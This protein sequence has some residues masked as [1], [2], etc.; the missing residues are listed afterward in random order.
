MPMDSVAVY[1]DPEASHASEIRYV[2]ELLLLTLGARYRSIFTLEESTSYGATLAYLRDPAV[3]LQIGTRVVAVQMAPSAPAFFAGDAAYPD[4]AIGTIVDEGTPIPVLFCDEQTVFDVDAGLATARSDGSIIIPLDFLSSAFWFL[5][6]REEAMS[7]HR[8][9]WGRFG[10]T[11]SLF[12]REPR[13]TMTV[14]DTYL[15]LL[16]KLLHNTLC[17]GGRRSWWLPRWP[18][19]APFAFCGTHDVDALRKWHPRRV[20]GE[21]GRLRQAWRTSGLQGAVRR[22]WR[23]VGELVHNPNPYD[24]VLELA[25]RERVLD[26]TATYFFLAGRH[27]PHDAQYDLSRDESVGHLIQ[28]VE[29]VGHEVGLHGSFTTLGDT[30]RL[31]EELRL[32][33]QYAGKVVGQRQHYLRFDSVVSWPAYAAVGIEYDSSLGFADQ[34]G[35]RAG[36]SF[37]IFPYDMKRHQVF[38]FVEI[39]LLVMDATLYAYRGLDAAD[40]WVE[41][42]AVLEHVARIEGCFTI[43][44]HNASFDDLDMPGYGDIY[45][46]AIEWAQSR[47]AWMASMADVSRWWMQR[48]SETGATWRLSLSSA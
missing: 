48:A 37:P 4:G 1:I 34:V 39:P 3:S 22:G 32:L 12:S 9:V 31:D 18:N 2:M 42:E 21:A 16:G 26:V 6:R 28:Q 38:P 23:V 17:A 7:S 11:E 33:R 15:A 40:A 27:H 14:V 10:Y 20:L 29:S 13:L 41:V 24:N 8:D 45:W 25:E 35:S 46:K 30:R 19:E 47:N 36:F 43:L 44:W 5:S